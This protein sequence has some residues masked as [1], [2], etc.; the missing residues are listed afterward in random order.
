MVDERIEDIIGGE[1]T[2]LPLPA[3]L[4][5]IL[6][7]GDT[8]ED[9]QGTAK[10]I[11]FENLQGLSVGATKTADFTANVGELY[12]IDALSLADNI[13][14]TFPSTPIEGDTFGYYIERQNTTDT[15]T[16]GF[17]SAPFWA[18][19][20]LNATVINN[21][22]Y[23]NAA[24]DGTEKWGVWLNGEILIYRYTDAT[25]GWQVLEDG[26][27]AQCV[28]LRRDATQSPTTSTF[29]QVNWDTVDSENSGLYNSSNDTIEVKRQ[30][31][32][33]QVLERLYFVNPTGVCSGSINRNSATAT[34]DPVDGLRDGTSLTKILVLAGENTF[35]VK[36]DVLRWWVY[37]TDTSS[38][39]VGHASDLSLQSR[40][41]FIETLI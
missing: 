8:A 21:E 5:V 40:G 26:R 28:F 32:S 18:C 2:K 30:A 22:A 17:T 25:H 34:T 39:T 3:D 20:P 23:T 31:V 10:N 33:Y 13:D 38:P 27:I 6:D 41:G 24:G 1:L 7:T 11:K 16:S 15:G 4:F 19:D 14:V 9:P 35:I 12:P 37:V 36:G 29:T